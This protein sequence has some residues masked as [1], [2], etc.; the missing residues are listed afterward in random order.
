VKVLFDAVQSAKNDSHC[1]PVE[2]SVDKMMHGAM[3]SCFTTYCMNFIEFDLLV[4][5]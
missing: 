1:G 5:S 2:V 4:T 3:T